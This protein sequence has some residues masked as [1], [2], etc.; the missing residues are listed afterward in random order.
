MAYALEEV[1]EVLDAVESAIGDT[2]RCREKMER[3]AE[4]GVDRLM[5]L[6]QFGALPQERILGS[7][8]RVGEQLIPLVAKA[9]GA[10]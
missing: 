2:D 3:Y 1:Y 4:I 10:G 9:G 8:R 6:H 5:C 7:I